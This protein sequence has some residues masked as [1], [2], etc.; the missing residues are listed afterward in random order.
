MFELGMQNGSSANRYIH[1]IPGR[2]RVRVGALKGNPC[3]AHKVAT[4]LREVEGVGQVEA[5]TLTGSVLIHYDH[6][7]TSGTQLLA[8]LCSH[9]HLQTAVTVRTPQR[10][11][12]EQ[13]FAEKAVKK[14]A[15]VAV[16]YVVESALE[17]AAFALIAA[18]L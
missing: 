6:Q 4:M 16:G 15:Q 12:V 3:A 8:L 1:H 11:R 9:G 5:N 14:L 17:R 7:T 18:V 10:A 13:Q 2:L